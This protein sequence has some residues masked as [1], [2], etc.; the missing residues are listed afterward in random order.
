M[1]DK[2]VAPALGED[3]FNCP[4]CGAFAHQTWYRTWMDDYGKDGK[5][6][7]PSEAAGYVQGEWPA[8]KEFDQDLRE[9]LKRVATGL[10]FVET[11]DTG[12]YSH[13]AVFNLSL[14][15]CYSCKKFAVWVG[16]KLVFPAREYPIKPHDDMP[17]EVATDFTE[18]A[19]IADASPRGAAA[20]LRLAIQKLMPH[21]GQKGKDLNT[22][23]GNL[24]TKGLDT[25]LQK[26]LDLVRVI[27]NNAVHPG[28]LDLK[29]DKPTTL[30]LFNLVNLIVESQISTPK[31]IVEMYES[32]MPQSNR[33]AI[34]KR[35]GKKKDS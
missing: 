22:D 16:A 6:W 30:R 24:V 14:S 34:A 5:P 23:I 12:G 32:V 1:S 10:V 18:A 29:D 27:G 21:L 31:H 20:L 9:F 2:I 15:Q 4:H 33:D 11:Q 19:A 7:N 28:Q 25:K 8:N 17:E 3:S 26:A 35:D 13:L